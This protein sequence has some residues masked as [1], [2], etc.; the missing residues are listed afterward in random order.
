VFSLSLPI[1][2]W[3]R[4]LVEESAS[5]NQTAQ[6]CGLKE[7]FKIYQSTIE[8]EF[9]AANYFDQYSGPIEEDTNEEHDEG[10]VEEDEETEAK[11]PH[12]G[13]Y[14][15]LFTRAMT[16]EYKGYLMVAGSFISF[17]YYRST[18]PLYILFQSWKYHTI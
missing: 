2:I 15:S 5:R 13:W 16:S 6:F 7:G 11:N 12:S 18:C 9:K 8:I 1:N 14:F 4:N 17:Y 10:E 3:G